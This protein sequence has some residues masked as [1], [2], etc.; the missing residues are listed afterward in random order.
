MVMSCLGIFD[1]LPSEIVEHI[2]FFIHINSMKTT[3]EFIN[4]FVPEPQYHIPRFV[5]YGL[6]ISSRKLRLSFGD[7]PYFNRDDTEIEH[8]CV[9]YISKTN[10]SVRNGIDL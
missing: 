1:R 9:K 10:R 4:K 3:F 8:W 7:H 5:G 6:G 2:H